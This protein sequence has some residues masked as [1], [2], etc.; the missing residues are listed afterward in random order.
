MQVE[1]E[2]ERVDVIRRDV[3]HSSFII[4]IYVFF[5]FDSSIKQIVFELTLAEDTKLIF[6]SRII[7][8]TLKKE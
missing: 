8:K 3:V 7:N 5:V 2:E 4:G 1:R 6:N